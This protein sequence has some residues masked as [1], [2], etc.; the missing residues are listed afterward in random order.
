MK[1]LFN[2]TGRSYRTSRNVGFGLACLLIAG[3]SAVAADSSEAT[4]ARANAQHGKNTAQVSQ[5]V[6]AA[7]VQGEVG[8][9][10]LAFEPN[11]GQTD[12]QVKYMARAQGYTAFLTPDSTVMQVKGP[13]K[14]DGY[15]AMRMVNGKT[16]GNFAASDKQI[17][18]SN[19]F[20]GNDHSKW[21]TNLTHYG[22]ITNRGVYP[23]IDVAYSGN[24]R[25]LEYDFVV[26]AGADPNQIRIAYD[27]F[28][29][30]A[31]NANGDLELK[32]AAGM[33]VA[34][35]P[36]VYQ[37]IGGTRQTVTGEYAMLSKNEVGFHLGSYDS[38]APL[39]ID[40]TI[41]T[42]AY[43]GGTG[44]DQGYSVAAVLPTATA[45][46]AA[47][48]FTGKTNSPNFPLNPCVHTYDAGCTVPP[49][50]N[51][52]V[53]T[54]LQGAIAGNY[55]CFV[56][57]LDKTGTKLIWS[58]YI[59]GADTDVCTG[60]AID[61]TLAPSVFVTGFT[62]STNGT[63]PLTQY[64]TTAI[65]EA[66]PA[67]AVVVGFVTKLTNA[68]LISYSAIIGSLGSTESL[69]IAVGSGTNPNAYI[70]GSVDTALSIAPAPSPN[71]QGGKM[72]GGL[73]DGFVAE[74]LGSS[75]A[76]TNGQLVFQAYI[77][78]TNAEQVSAI[79]V[80]PLTQDVYLAGTTA[81]VNVTPQP[82]LFKLF[83]TTPGAYTSSAFTG[84]VG[85]AMEIP[86]AAFA[87]GS[88]I[89]TG[90]LGTPTGTATLCPTGTAL[91]GDGRVTNTDCLW[92]STFGGDGFGVGHETATGIAVDPNLD[93]LTTTG[94][95]TG[96][97]L[98]ESGRMVYVVG[99]TQSFSFNAA[100]GFTTPSPSFG[101]APL[102]GRNAGYLLGITAAAPPPATP[103][104]GGSEL[105]FLGYSATSSF[106]TIGGPDFVGVG[107]FLGLNNQDNPSTTFNGVTVDQESQ[108]YVIG[109]AV[110]Q[111]TGA[112][113][114]D[115]VL[116]RYFLNTIPA[117]PAW[118]QLGA[119]IAFGGLAADEG[120]GV[121][122][123]TG[124]QA[125][126]VGTTS[127]TGT[128]LTT[129]APVPLP[130]SG[131][132]CTTAPDLGIYDGSN[133]A[134]PV[135]PTDCIGSA[136]G[137]GTNDAF[138]AGVQYHD[139]VAAPLVLS[140]SVTEGT[141]ATMATPSALFVSAQFLSPTG[142][143]PAGCVSPYIQAVNSTGGTN[144]SPFNVAL[145]ETS[146]SPLFVTY[147]VTVQPFASTTTPG[148]EPV[149]L[150]LVGDPTSCAD[151]SVQVDLELLVK[152][153]L[154]T[155]PLSIATQEIWMSGNITAAPGVITQPTI[156]H[157]PVRIPVTVTTSGGDIPFTTSLTSP[158]LELLN[159]TCTLVSFDGTFA[160]TAT[161]A[162][163]TVNVIVHP[164]CFNTGTPL[165]VYAANITIT[166]DDPSLPAI[167]IPFTLTVAG[168]VDVTNGSG[169]VFTFP[170]TAAAPQSQNI[171]LNAAG[172]PFTYIGTYVPSTPSPT[173]TPLPAGA[174]TFTP[175]PGVINIDGTANVLMIVNPAG[176]PVGTTLTGTVYL[177]PTA[178]S[179]PF[180]TIALPVTVIVD[181]PS[182]NGGLFVYSP[183]NTTCNPQLYGGCINSNLPTGF[184]GTAPTLPE[185]ARTFKIGDTLTTN[186]FAF[187]SINGPTNPIPGVVVTAGS[188][189]LSVGPDAG[190]C[191]INGF[192][193]SPN[194]GT[195]NYT[196]IIDPFGLAPGNYVG[197]I[198]VTQNASPF[199]STIVF[200]N[201]TVTSIPSLTLVAT[202]TPPPPGTL[203]PS[204]TGTVY[205]YVP[206]TTI[207]GSG[208]V[209]FTPTAGSPSQVCTG[210]EFPPTLAGPRISLE[211]NAGSIGDTSIT[212]SVPW[213]T[214]SS[215][216]EIF[217]FN[218]GSTNLTAVATGP[219]P[220][221]AVRSNVL[222]ICVTPSLASST[223]GTFFG[224]VII[225]SPNSSNILTIPVTL[226]IG[227]GSP[228]VI[229][230]GNIGVF[231]AGTFIE[232][233]NLP[234]YDYSAGTTI[235]NAFGLAGDQPV[236]GDWLGTGN[237]SIGVFR[238]GAFFLDLNNDGAFESNE[239]PFYFGQAGDVAVVG[240]WNGTHTTKLGVFRCP[241][242]PGPCT[243]YLL[244]ESLTSALLVPGANLY[245]APA[246]LV[247]SYG[248]TGDLPV[249]S[250]WSQTGPVD[251]IGVVRCPA[252]PASCTW[253]VD[254][255]G[256]GVYNPATPTYSFGQLGDQPVVGDWELI[257][258]PKRIGVYRSSTG[259]WILDV[260]GSNQYAPNDIGAPG[261]N[262]GLF[263]LAG[264]T[265]K[266]VVGR[267][268]N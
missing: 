91:L 31:L 198:T 205:S 65:S 51:A 68:G 5:K 263:G 40:P 11:R 249:A 133:G 160:G 207:P 18:V 26:A 194:S 30:M 33:T 219:A 150:N 50:G 109:N 88:T 240:D 252:L 195:C 14:T 66:Y 63:L 185:F 265:D 152:S 23:G 200:V 210:T 39:I 215:F 25:D 41:T 244:N 114:V 82:T 176:L 251:Q 83:P 206:S 1:S 231:R 260:N 90:T 141:P 241:P 79:T 77:G 24:D 242:V 144:F 167:S 110:N 22:K 43:L 218:L 155:S 217:D 258:H 156:S 248:M 229:D 237:V 239:G 94:T 209:V 212:T 216:S 3:M 174:L 27:G 73:T 253:Y 151:N 127:S 232:N 153:S 154:A 120:F 226:T 257:G 177:N 59:G 267:W 2:T 99:N 247:Y 227:S 93:V 85:F 81:S 56:T 183:G 72:N 208:G 170:S 54:Q 223:G 130:V 107:A 119:T 214:A 117:T 35:K 197:Q 121:A 53:G 168:G 246:T 203:L 38:S 132:P 264:G 52:V 44:N 256:T 103:P 47:I 102:F 140:F 122:V 36:I 13:G 143:I 101:S 175:S 76:A 157:L 87:T 259:T 124:Q 250:N 172:G 266:P 69:A 235:T 15:L 149:L 92:S 245:S 6:T 113:S 182:P 158:N 137:G 96:N 243:W 128:S 224:N 123:T 70:G 173:S 21:L 32:T 29:S 268:T 202:P 135:T 189:W 255:A 171:T 42:L 16:S 193:V 19:Y 199:Y 57:A 105:A 104:T 84:T 146:P 89:G 211:S 60:V 34:H 142:A 204:L 181:G 201:L 136:Y 86:A 10:P 78:G 7:Q 80:D 9:L 61:S 111:I 191:S 45:T 126:V 138:I 184:T 188:S 261:S 98:Y 8:K 233:L 17:G 166:P 234:S 213:L 161:T 125:F 75:S 62:N 147:R 49:A 37:L 262:T 225:S 228:G 192:F 74:F 58:T 169:V 134:T 112:S 97:E 145:Y 115:A 159:T 220:F 222:D 106:G 4:A 64:P 116:E 139:I 148:G 187:V 190:V 236:A 48:F 108:I 164:D 230:V 221:D 254:V 20:I 179:A 165:G 163:T 162:G 100:T 178:A 71:F 238:N 131:V 67:G 55:D 118:Q 28:T 180:G 95:V 129:T 196:A 46:S 186:P 12:A